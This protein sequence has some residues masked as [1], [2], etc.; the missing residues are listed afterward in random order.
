MSNSDS[1]TSHTCV[2][3]VLDNNR[4]LARSY[5]TRWIYASECQSVF[6]PSDADLAAISN[7]A[8]SLEEVD[9]AR[10]VITFKRPSD[11][12]NHSVTFGRLLS[13]SADSGSTSILFIDRVRGCQLASLGMRLAEQGCIITLEK[14]LLTAEGGETALSILVK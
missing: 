2:H 1:K 4:A 12:R 7:F 10:L 9:H 3:H 5:E 6:N 13:T 11:L 8:K 14:C